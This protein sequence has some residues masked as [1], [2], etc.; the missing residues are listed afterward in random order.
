MRA[1][2]APELAILAATTRQITPRIKVA[3]GS[4]TMIDVS[5]WME[6][7]TIQ[8]DIDQPVDGCTV[9]FRRD[10]GTTQSLSPLRTDSTLNRDDTASYSPLLD[11]ARPVTVEIATTAIGAAIVA[12]DR[13]LLFSG[14]IDI[15]NFEH[16]PVSISCRD[17]GGVLVDRWIETIA[18]YGSI[19]LGIPLETVIQQI[20]NANFG[21]GIIPLYTPSSPGF[22]ITPIYQ[23]QKMSVQDALLQLAQ[24]TGWDV[25][26]RWDD[27]T[28]AF[29]LTLAS[30]PRGKTTPDYTFG[31]SS[32]FDITQLFLDRTNIR[33]V[34]SG[35]YLDSATKSR[36]VAIVID[37][38]SATRYGRRYYEIQEGDTSPID[39]AAEMNT[40]LAAALSDLKDP[41]AEQEI[42]LPFFW[43]ADLWDL[44]RFSPN[45]V[46]YNQNQDYAVVSIR[47]EIARNHHRTI[48]TVRGVP[49][50]G[51]LTWLGRRAGTGL[52]QPTTANALNNFRVTAETLNDITYSWDAGGE[53]AEVWE[54][55]VEFSVPLV[56]NPWDAVLA[57]V[58]PLAPG[59]TSLTFTKPEEGNLLLVQ[60]EPRDVSLQPGQVQRLVV[61][62]APTQAPLV[63][64][65]DI[66]NTA[67]ATQWFK[68]TERGLLV[69]DVK[70][71]TQIGVAPISGFASPT[72]GPGGTSL[73]KGGSLGA[74]EYEQDILLDPTRQSYIDGYV[75]LNNGQQSTL[76]IWTFDRDKNPNILALKVTLTIIEVL[77]DSDTKSIKIT[78]LSSGW[79]YWVDGVSGYVDVA[80]PD[81][82]G[83][84]GL[85]TAASDT[86]IV[87]AYSD[88]KAFVTGGSLS[89]ARNI[90]VSGGTA[91]PA[92]A[93]WQTVAV[94]APAV[95]S[96]VAHITLKASAAPAGYNV[97]VYI[98]VKLGPSATPIIDRTGSLTPALGAPPTVGTVY[99]YTA[100]G[101][102]AAA[103]PGFTCTMTVACDLRNAANVVVDTRTVIAT[104]Y[105]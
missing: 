59:T 64:L 98:N 25:R 99:A 87:T 20:L 102:T 95:G 93:V 48:L 43:P 49:A 1:A 56:P 100:S 73:V 70:V 94:S 61:H 10:Q 53:V 55:D 17:L 86:Y 66:E 82:T 89:E 37:A 79:S 76:G 16:S 19:G 4:G 28:S 92:G 18:P 67:D 38:T 77:C 24:L 27:A 36:K 85:G 39:T 81:E 91:P 13:K 90:Q 6:R 96:N 7:V 46:H 104:W 29:R 41:K 62:A 54:G 105:V 12:G 34:I 30:V 23:Q 21:I 74:L 45:S 84:A 97:K 8:R 14:A 65:D 11:V 83:N 71:R 101:F 26:Y 33:N 22:P 9:E 52:P 5:T 78:A 3:N 15:T 75:S 69:T 40:M 57:V 32:Y 103:G 68:L 35:S 88:P 72:R 47:H 80:L 63:T 31:P 44:Y 58:S 2:T 42:E 51:Y 60:I 50:G